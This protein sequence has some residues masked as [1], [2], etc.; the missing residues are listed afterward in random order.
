MQL[1]KQH[2]SLALLT[3]IKPR[4]QLIDKRLPYSL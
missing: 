1:G 3:V 2:Q 4:Y